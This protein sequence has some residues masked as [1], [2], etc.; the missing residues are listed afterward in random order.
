MDF[1]DEIDRQTDPGLAVHVIW[2]NCEDHG[3]P[4]GGRSLTRATT[5]HSCLGV[6]LSATGLLRCVLPPAR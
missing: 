3:V 4:Q 2:D 1:L 6:E 5:G